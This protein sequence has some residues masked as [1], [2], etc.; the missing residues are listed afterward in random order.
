MQLKAQTGAQDW[1]VKL[2]SSIEVLRQPEFPAR[3]LE[4]V[5]AIADVDS[6]VIMAYGMEPRPKVLHDEL[7]EE[8]RDAFYDR[9]LPGA[10]LL[11][12]L[13]QTFRAGKQGFFHLR[14]ISP[15]GFF[16]SEYYHKYYGYSGLIDQVFYLKRFHS[17]IAIIASLARTKK[18]RAYT[19]SEIDSLK[20]LEPVLLSLI[21]KQWEYLENKKLSFSD[22]LQQ[23]FEKFGCSVLT[24]REKQVVN[25]ILRGESSK[26]VAREMGISTET[27]RSYRKII[28]RKLDVNSHSQLYHLFFLSL[29]FAE[30]SEEHDPLTLLK[31][32]QN[33][34]FNSR[35]DSVALF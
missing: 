14:E 24:R 11:S 23:A 20:L 26:S 12:P 10:F 2:A 3:Y 25:C 18:F 5:R 28:Y 8:Y 19:Q 9:Y 34:G 16:D 4:L 22:Y 29:D 7:A 35:G 13:Y 15:D 33:Q 30:H 27:E 31:K 32:S 17:G 6:A 21:T 1:Q